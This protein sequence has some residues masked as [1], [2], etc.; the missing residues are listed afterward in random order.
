M[1]K[2][3][4]MLEE[5]NMSKVEKKRNHERLLRAKESYKLFWESQGGYDNGKR[6]WK[7]K[8]S[9]DESGT[10]APADGNISKDGTP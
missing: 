2:I 3:R 8:A 1:T 7:R 4:D 6:T 10:N 9:K 5:E